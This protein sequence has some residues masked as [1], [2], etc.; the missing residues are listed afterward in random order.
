MFQS[1]FRTNC[2]TCVLS[3]VLSTALM[4]AMGPFTV[5]IHLHQS[6]TF[7]IDPPC[8]A[9]CTS[10]AQDPE[11]AMELDPPLSP[12]MYSYTKCYIAIQYRLYDRDR[13]FIIWI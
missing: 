8:R 1:M 12:F 13:G 6:E 7:Q 3:K 11:P 9:E 10:G 5:V 2:E 4:E